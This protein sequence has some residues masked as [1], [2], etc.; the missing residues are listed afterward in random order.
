[1]HRAQRKTLPLSRAAASFRDGGHVEANES[2]AAPGAVFSG[3]QPPIVVPFGA[4]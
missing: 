3:N 4:V 1:M 2:L